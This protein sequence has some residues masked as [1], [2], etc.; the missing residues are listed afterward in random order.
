[1]FPHP[2]SVSLFKPAFFSDGRFDQ[3]LLGDAMSIKRM[4]LPDSVARVVLIKAGQVLL[5]ENRELEGL[6]QANETVQVTSIDPRSGRVLESQELRATGAG[7][8]RAKA[9]ER[10]TDDL[11]KKA[12]ETL[13][14]TGRP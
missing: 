6:I 2:V 8:S 4:S 7:F 14:S 10:M 5:S 1:M 13:A 3:A 11:G 12:R 9:L